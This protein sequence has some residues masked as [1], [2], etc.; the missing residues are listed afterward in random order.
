MLYI[1]CQPCAGHSASLDTDVL[2][3]WT[4]HWVSLLSGRFNVR[5][6]AKRSVEFGMWPLSHHSVSTYTGHPPHARLHPRHGPAGSSATEKRTKVSPFSAPFTCRPQELSRGSANLPP[7]PSNTE[8]IFQRPYLQDLSVAWNQGCL[9]KW[10]LACGPEV[11]AQTRCGYCS[12]PGYSPENGRG[13]VWRDPGLGA[14][15][16]GTPDIGMAVCPFR[17]LKWERRFMG[18]GGAAADISGGVIVAV[19]RG[20]SLM[21]RSIVSGTL[22]VIF[23]FPPHSFAALPLASCVFMGDTTE[24]LFTRL[25]CAIKPDYQGKNKCA[26]YRDRKIDRNCAFP[27]LSYLQHFT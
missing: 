26:K 11:W 13:G 25:H 23:T 6:D 3:C 20:S 17:L 16:N 12:L 8:L 22:W 10:A 21:N 2:I 24:S 5:W 19:L 18:G 4:E 15:S 27:I 1:S 9:S 14:D 7:K